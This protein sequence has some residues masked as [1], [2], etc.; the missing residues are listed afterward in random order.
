MIVTITEAPSLPVPNLQT[1]HRLAAG[2]YIDCTGELQA[3]CRLR[4]CLQDCCW[5]VADEM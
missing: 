2:L 3:T 1:C 5:S 4:E